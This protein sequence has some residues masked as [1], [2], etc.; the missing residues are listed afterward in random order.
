[1]KTV[2]LDLTAQEL[3]TISAALE[4]FLDVNEDDDEAV[5]I[6]KRIHQE[7]RLV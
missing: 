5:E 2:S 7:L 4:V 6:E 3:L 1:M